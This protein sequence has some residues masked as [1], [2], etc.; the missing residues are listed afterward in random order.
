MTNPLRMGIIGLGRCWQRRYQPALRAMRD[1]YEIRAVFDPVFQ[2]AEHAAQQLE[3]EAVAGLVALLERDDLDA[4]LLAD[5]QWFGLWP[6]EVACRLK[7]P[8]FCAISLDLEEARA[9]ALVQQVMAS[10]LPVMVEMLP[11]Y[12]PATA[13]LRKLLQT[14]LGPVRFLFADVVQPPSD[15]ED[16]TL[17]VLDWCTYLTDSTPQSVQAAGMDSAGV[18]SQFWEFTGGWGLQILQRQ[19]QQ[20]APAIRLEVQTEQGTAHVTLPRRIAWTS[21][22]GQ[23]RLLL[24]AGPPLIQMQLEEFYEAVRGGQ[25]ALEPGLADMHCVLGWLRAARCSQAEGRRVNL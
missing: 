9:E 21:F 5:P 12:A 6:L 17:P 18:T 3:C 20:A 4:V 23:H 10:G 19:A 11:R 8:V 14:S 24:P 15:A 13:R 7:K 22:E 1:R 25:S 2:Y 16:F